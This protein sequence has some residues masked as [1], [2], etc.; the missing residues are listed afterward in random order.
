MLCSLP[1]LLFL[2]VLVRANTEIVNFA[3]D[4]RPE[5]PPLL[6]HAQMRAW[7]VLASVGAPSEWDLSRAVLG[8]ALD[9]LCNG[10]AHL[11]EDAEDNINGGCAGEF[12][13]VLA[14]AGTNPGA[15]YTL[16]LSWAASTPT[17]FDITVLDPG[18]AAALL[19][20]PHVPSATPGTETRAKH[21]AETRVK[22]ARI[23]AVDAGVLTPRAHNNSLLSLY[24]PSFPSYNHT[25]PP[26]V[27]I[28]L[29]LEPLLLGF[30]PATLLPLLAVML[31]LLLGVGVGVVPRAVRFFGELAGEA[32]DA[33]EKG[34]KNE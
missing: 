8:S 19:R 32:R 29:T 25:N 9:G 14:L 16:R 1:L 27:H 17:D 20:L 26:P 33:E 24:T 34:R 31:P 10:D 2:L 15:R 22:Y 21:T 28:H 30:L 11:D 12:W 18:A 13:V 5:F 4:A 23:R 7:P 6:L 3:A